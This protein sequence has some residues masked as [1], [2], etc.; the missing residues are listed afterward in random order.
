M[1]ALHE[2]SDLGLCSGPADPLREKRS[3][4]PPISCTD[5]HELDAVRKKACRQ[6]LNLT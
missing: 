5:E 2:H 3:Y 1:T 4:L 6:T